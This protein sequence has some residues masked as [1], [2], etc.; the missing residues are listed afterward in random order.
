M[1]NEAIEQI[2][3]HVRLAKGHGYHYIYSNHGETALMIAGL[4]STSIYVKETGLITVQ[5]WLRAV[6]YLLE[7]RG[8]YD[9]E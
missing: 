9:D 6:T 2:Y 3:P 7:E 8:V 5:Q 4:F 1:V